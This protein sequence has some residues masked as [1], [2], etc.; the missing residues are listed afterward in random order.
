MLKSW[1]AALDPSQFPINALDPNS[2]A[3]QSP[4]VIYIH[5]GIPAPP[6]DV[7]VF[8]ALCSYQAYH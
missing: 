8:F 4:I 5:L 2:V 6:P 1:M 7:E 3:S